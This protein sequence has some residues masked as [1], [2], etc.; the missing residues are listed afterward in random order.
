MMAAGELSVSCP[1]KSFQTITPEQDRQQLLQQS[2]CECK[3]LL[4]LALVPIITL[5]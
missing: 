1:Y 3:H 4:S 2:A 5:R